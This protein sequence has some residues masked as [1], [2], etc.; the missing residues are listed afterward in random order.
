MARYRKVDPK[1][2]N[3]E[4]FRALSDDGKLAFFM[5]LTHPH[6]TA[7]G[8]MRAMPSGMASEMA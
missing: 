2:W 5:L 4:K 8:A 6:M 3:D 7:V 1:I